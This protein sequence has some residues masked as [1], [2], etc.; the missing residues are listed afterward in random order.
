MGTH[1]ICFYDERGEARRGGAIL[2]STHNI[3]FYQINQI[4][5]SALSIHI[6][7]IAYNNVYIYE[8]FYK[9]IL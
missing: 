7:P 4:L 6:M 5:Y 1:N 2:M 3:Y 8:E 9:I